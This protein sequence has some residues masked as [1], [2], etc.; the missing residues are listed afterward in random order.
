MQ[1]DN[2]SNAPAQSGT[3]GQ[4]QQTDNEQ[5]RLPDSAEKRTEEMSSDISHV[6]QQEGQMNNGT[7]GGN[8]DAGGTQS[9]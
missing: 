9:A 6:D 1:Q 5:G 7:L 2:K 3:A 8:F 4:P